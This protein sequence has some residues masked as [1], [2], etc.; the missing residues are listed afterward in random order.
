MFFSDMIYVYLACIVIGLILSVLSLAF[1]M[2]SGL[3]Y[4]NV[5]E[6]ET[7]KEW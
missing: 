2:K 1:G 7:D 3:F 6:I 4:G 5:S